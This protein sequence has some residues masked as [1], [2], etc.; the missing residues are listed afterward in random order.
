M[1]ASSFLSR[2]ARMHHVQQFTALRAPLHAAARG[3]LNN[4]RDLG[5]IDKIVSSLPVR[6]DETLPKLVEFTQ[7]RQSAQFRNTM[8]LA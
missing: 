6:L 1:A 7:L 5:A 8:L 3:N 2:C 4:S